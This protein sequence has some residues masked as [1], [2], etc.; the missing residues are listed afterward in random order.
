MR[1]IILLEGA[2]S[3]MK[4][5]VSVITIF[6]G[7]GFSFNRIPV[8]AKLAAA[9]KIIP[10]KIMTL[11]GEKI[12]IDRIKDISR[13]AS[14]KAGGL[15]ERYVCLATL[16]DRQQEIYLYNDEKDWFMEDGF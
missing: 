11:Q 7:E 6:V 9:Y 8:S 12:I 1:W 15:G 3:A 13:Q 14:T 4:I 16:G 2:V 10:L 5:P